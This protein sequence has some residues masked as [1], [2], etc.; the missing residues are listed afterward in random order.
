[1]TSAFLFRL[2]LSLIA[3]GSLL[4]Y[5]LSASADTLLWSPN[6][7]SSSTSR[8]IPMPANLGIDSY[9]SSVTFDCVARGWG[10]V[11]SIHFGGFTTSATHGVIVRAN[12]Q[13]PNYV[14]NFTTTPDTNASSSWAN[15]IYCGDNTKR[16]VT[17]DF[18]YNNGSGA[19]RVYGDIRTGS[20]QAMDLNGVWSSYSGPA[21]AGSGV[22]G[23]FMPQLFIRGDLAT[24][25]G[26]G[27][28]TTY[29]FYT[30]TTSPADSIDQQTTIQLVFFILL[31]IALSAILT[32]YAIYAPRTRTD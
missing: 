17:L 21:P 28:S 16:L 19:L 13:V 24:S 32:Y 12:G 27:D 10:K 2:V 30:A 31:T 5:A 22:A 26:S 9:R 18:I 6:D 25:S 1:M 20:S 11:N 23:T 15:G 8:L 7:T 4:S 29:N 14:A 3:I